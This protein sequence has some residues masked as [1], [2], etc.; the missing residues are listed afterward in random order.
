MTRQAYNE[1]MQLEG[2]L[3]KLSNDVNEE[4]DV[5]TFI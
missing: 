1:M 3:L 2:D 5:W 4:K